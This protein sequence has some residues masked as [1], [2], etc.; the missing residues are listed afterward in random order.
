MT[1]KQWYT[2]ETRDTQR[3]CMRGENHDKSDGGRSCKS[4]KEGE[5]EIEIA[6]IVI[7]FFNKLQSLAY[8]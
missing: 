2:E 5:R 4:E 1:V 6:V 3:K 7:F 8:H